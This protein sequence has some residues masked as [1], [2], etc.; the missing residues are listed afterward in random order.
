M[1]DEKVT[2][3]LSQDEALVLFSWLSRLNESDGGSFEDQAEERVL[4]DVEAMLEK[5]LVAPLA[6]NYE[7]LLA[8]ARS[9]VRDS[10]E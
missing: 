6:E 9:N 8:A 10:E 7:E 4:W 1:T 5:S 2:I 3:E